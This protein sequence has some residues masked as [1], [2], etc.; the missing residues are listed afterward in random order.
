MSKFKIGAK[1]R[2]KGSSKIVTLIGT[3]PCGLHWNFVRVKNAFGGVTA[4]P[5]G[6]FELVGERQLTFDWYKDEV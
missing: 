2:R 1:L 6:C 5:E 4:L 3:C